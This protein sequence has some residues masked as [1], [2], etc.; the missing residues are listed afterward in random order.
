MRILVH[1]AYVFS[2]G[3][4]AGLRYTTAVAASAAEYETPM[5]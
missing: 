3:A 4:K 5:S 1:L 2:L